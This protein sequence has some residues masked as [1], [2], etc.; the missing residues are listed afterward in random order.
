M[1]LGVAAISSADVLQAQLQINSDLNSMDGYGDA[2]NI[3]FAFDLNSVFSGFG[4]YSNFVLTKIGWDVT[5]T[6]EGASWL[7]E[8]AVE[9]A[10][11]TTNNDW[12]WLRPGA[13]SANNHNG[14]Q[15]FSS[16]GLVTLTGT[17]PV[18]LNA[19]N[20]LRME[21]FESFNDYANQ[22]DGY[23]HAG[24]TIDMEFT[25]DLVPEPASMAVLGLGALALIRRRK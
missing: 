4:N 11:S 9:F 12:I 10:D 21:F 13:G 14:T 1:L 20:I 2:D 16:G 3:V 18:V 25:A 17:Q 22:R 6:A 8:L 5:L 23:W 7:S 15:S 24:S 19:D